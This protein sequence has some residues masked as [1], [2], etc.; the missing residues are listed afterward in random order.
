VSSTTEGARG[1]RRTRAAISTAAAIVAAAALAGPASANLAAVS[2]DISAF[3]FPTYY[4]DS[5]PLQVGLCIEDPGCPASPKAG[6]M[7]AP[8]GE[9]FYQLANATVTGT[10]G[11]SV[12]V[13]FNVEAAF[14]DDTPITFGRIQFTAHNLEPGATYTVD[15][16]YG[17]SH[18]TVD[19]N[20]DLVGGRRAAQREET[21]GSFDGTLSSAIGPF[22]R[23]TSAPTGYLGNG[24]TE[25]TVTGGS[26]R[27]TVT[28]TGPGLPPAATATDPVTGDTIIVRPAGLTTDQFVVE[29]KVFDPTAPVPVPPIP[30]PLD[31][32]GDGV[33][34]SFDRCAFQVGPAT[35]G[36]CPI[37][38]PG[39]RGQAAQGQQSA[40]GT[41]IIQVIPGPAGAVLATTASS[42]LFVSQLTLARRISVSRL[43]VQGLRGSMSVQQGTN[44]LRFGVYKARNGQK[45]GRALYTT[46]RTPTHAGLY[47]FSLRS[48]KLSK[49][50]AGRYVLE[51][52]A[53]RSAASLGPV[54]QF[55]FTVTR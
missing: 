25:T 35:N 31:S 32:D 48:T 18:F 40:A 5:T 6:D 7:K 1:R 17:Q 11:E 23:S 37:I 24:V 30:V 10:G 3:G 26:V 44:V 38:G 15:H 22:L 16:P 42:R 21:D 13:D 47:R 41:T 19:D 49:L 51:V 33:V 39:P 52:R 34:D 29:G 2:P 20:G 28:V 50:K 53:G 9:A 43:R 55:A 14:L 4:Q 46:S 45:T 8:D 36:G 54:K 12:T 27:N